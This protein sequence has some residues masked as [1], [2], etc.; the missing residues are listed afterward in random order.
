MSKVAD[1]NNSLS[2]LELYLSK[3]STP[4]SVSYEDIADS[5][6]GKIVHIETERFIASSLYSSKKTYDEYSENIQQL[7]KLTFADPIVMEKFVIGT[8]RTP[9]PFQFQGLVNS[10]SMRWEKGYPFAAFMVTDKETDTV[11]GYEV[12]GNTG[13]D[14]TGELVYLFNKHYHRSETIQNVGY[15]NVGALCLVYGESL[16]KA[17]KKVN[18][19]Y[20]EEKQKFDYGSEFIKLQATARDDNL[21]SKRILEKIGCKYIK[22][23]FKFEHNNHVFEREY[24][25]ITV[26]QEVGNSFY[27]NS[28]TMGLMGEELMASN[29]VHS[30]CCFIW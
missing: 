19:T 13:I 17:K 23:D 9:E 4:P 12:I 6:R 24:T 29:V 18:Q 16:F 8:A 3:F 27:D 28:I 20:N 2:P 5:P 30:N 25:E 14:N 15:E 26:V 10:Q 22:D 7:Y 11:V 1:D 21:A